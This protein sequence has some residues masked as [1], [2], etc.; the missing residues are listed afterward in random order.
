MSQSMLARYKLIIF[1]WDGT[2]MDSVPKI[3]DS[4]HRAASSIPDLPVRTDEEFKATIGQ[5]IEV[6]F[7]EL[8]PDASNLQ[9]ESWLV[10]FRD[11]FFADHSV[12]KQLFHSALLLLDQLKA[13]GQLIAVATGKKRHG[14]DK[15]LAN[16]ALLDFFDATRC[17]DETASKPD[18]KMVVEILEKLNCRPSD[19]LLIGDSHHDMQLAVNAGVDALGLTH[20]VA[21]R[22]ILE[23]YQ[24]IAI[25]DDLQ[26]LLEQ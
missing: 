1:D 21:D 8:Y 18:P 20:G 11:A 5:S 9:Q 6:A 12:G 26:E 24:P 25:A 10:A 22:E 7:S 2:L 3:I 16:N 19:A 23:Q 4:F 15:D 17:S 14:L 13:N